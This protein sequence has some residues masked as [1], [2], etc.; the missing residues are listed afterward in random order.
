MIGRR[1]QGSSKS[2]QGVWRRVGARPR[3]RSTLAAFLT[4]LAI[5]GLGLSS[6]RA[7]VAAGLVDRLGDR[8]SLGASRGDHGDASSE[9]GFPAS[10]IV[11]TPL[12]PTASQ[13]PRGAVPPSIAFV[14]T[15]PRRSV[16]VRLCDGYYFPIGPLSQDSDF[17][18]HEAACA[19]LCPDAPTRLFVETGGS[20][21]IE[22]AVSGDGARYAALPTA[23]HN[24]ARF[25][26]AC[27]CHRRVSLGLPLL[28]DFTLRNGDAIMTSSGIMVFRG[29]GHG[30]FS[31]DDFTT[32]ANAALPNDRRAVLAAMESTAVPDVDRSSENS[33]APGHSEIAFAAPPA[34]FSTPAPRDNSIRFVEPRSASN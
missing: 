12:T 2:D 26:K 17:S 16:C 20:D 30:P 8:L 32:L 13:A 29:A 31:Q 3:S 21:R 24:R 34:A 22:D 5:F 19:S 27:A 10:N 1:V 7:G 9:G 18:D 15:A 25:D 14:S 4:G 28:E 23:F 6:L 33:T 11:W